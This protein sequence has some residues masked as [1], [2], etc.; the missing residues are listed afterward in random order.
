MLNAIRIENLRSIQDSK[1][2]DLKSLNILVGANSSG[3]S[4]FL[5][6]F[7]LLSQSINK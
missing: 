3:K 1:F 5:R 4:T 6:S 2:I 7:P